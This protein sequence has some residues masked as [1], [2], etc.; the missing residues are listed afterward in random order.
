MKY[1][2]DILESPDEG[3][4]D[5]EEEAE[6]TLAVEVQKD[7]QNVYTPKHLI[8]GTGRSRKICRTCTHYNT[9]NRLPL[10]RLKGI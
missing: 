2:G 10:Q 4:S 6:I 9:F 8:P 3:D 1:A 7:T 5:M